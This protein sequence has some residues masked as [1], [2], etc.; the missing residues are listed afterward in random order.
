MPSEH[1]VTPRRLLEALKA[2]C[3]SRGVEIRTN[4]RVDEVLH[5]GRRVTGVR[6]GDERFAS[7]AVVIASGAWSGEIAG[8]EPQIPVRPRKGQ[9]LALAAEKPTFGRMIRW[10]N[11][12]FIPRRDGE[13]I[14]GAT[15]EDAGFNRAL[16]PAGIGGLLAEAQQLAAS[17]GSHSI[18]EM[19]SGFRPATADALP[20]IG[21]A[22]RE[23][24]FYATGH[25]RNGILLAPITAIIVS[26]LIDGRTLDLPL[27]P[28]SPAR[29]GS[30]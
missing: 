29:F 24:L 16:T 26:A 21:R 19:W 6:A 3:L 1:H 30:D 2:A 15:N 22:G 8:L 14:V 5:N 28:Y 23:G 7:N 9:I 18:A 4:A 17:T 20:I 10:G 12:Y 11:I 27:E 25:Y 13:L